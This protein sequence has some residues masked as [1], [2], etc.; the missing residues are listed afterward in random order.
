MSIEY[1]TRRATGPILSLSDYRSS[2][3]LPHKL[4]ARLFL[5][6]DRGSPHGPPFDLAFHIPSLPDS[7]FLVFHHNVHTRLTANPAQIPLLPLRFGDHSVIPIAAGC[8]FLV[9]PI[10]TL[11]L[12]DGI[13]APTGRANSVHVT[14]FV[15]NQQ[16]ESVETG[17]NLGQVLA[18]LLEVTRQ[19]LRCPAGLF[20]IPGNWGRTVGGKEG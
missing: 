14:R 19:W 2:P 16:T 20:G 4:H 11:R 10:S 5:L 17:R 6:L 1:A 9:R 13:P 15:V 7:L 12:A 18:K 8:E 3:L